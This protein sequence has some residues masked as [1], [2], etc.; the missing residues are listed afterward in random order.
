MGT[1]SQALANLI[2]DTSI[3]LPGSVIQRSSDAL[4]DGWGVAFAGSRSTVA[5][6]V[7][8]SFGGSATAGGAYAVGRGQELTMLDAA[9]YN[10]TAAHALDFDDTLLSARSHVTSHLLPALISASALADCDGRSAITAYAIGA[11]VEARVGKLLD[12]RNAMPRGWH[13]TGV[14]GTIGATATAARILGLDENASEMA[15]GIAA[16]MAS[17][18]RL[19]IGTMTKP[20][21]SGLAAR[22]GVQAAILA[23][24]G[25]TANE[26]AWD[27]Q[28]W[29]V[30][31]ELAGDEPGFA[32]AAQDIGSEWSLT[33]E[34]GIAL[35]PYPSC[36]PTHA[37]IEAVE[38]LRRELGDATEDLASV[39]VHVTAATASML[40]YTHPQTP[41]EAKF[42][43]QFCVAAALLGDRVGIAT[44]TRE[45]LADERIARLAKL[46]DV[47][48]DCAPEA[49]DGAVV[50]LRTTA[51]RTYDRGGG[52][53]EGLAGSPA[54]R[55]GNQGEI[56]GLLCRRRDQPDRRD[57]RARRERA[58]LG[59]HEG[60]ARRNR[61]A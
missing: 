18:A 53:G 33:E 15:L 23:R 48:P 28:D 14:I 4:I 8:N 11:E 40:R 37:A 52:Q 29:G 54:V 16:S 56:P 32:G 7:F 46:V 31:T 59:L 6:S 49:D 27:G 1:F 38:A 55:A 9:L 44:F 30:L 50:S 17:G 45:K 2:A 26:D 43:M 47:V 61:C 42:S 36:A 39:T 10:G 25:V 35:K 3:E 58:V 12:M 20:I 34:F 41:L 5:D 19:N 24:E 51:G 60:T 21:R 57:V 13:P 22:N